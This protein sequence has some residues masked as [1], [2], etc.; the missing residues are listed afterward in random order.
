MLRRIATDDPQ[1]VV[2]DGRGF[3]CLSAHIC[4]GGYS[5]LIAE[6]TLKCGQEWEAV[7]WRLLKMV[8][9]LSKL[10]YLAFSKLPNSQPGAVIT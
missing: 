5:R 1:Y 7:I 6:I 8:G 4:F 10:V 2:H 9:Y 3:A